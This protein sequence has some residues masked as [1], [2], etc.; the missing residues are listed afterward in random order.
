MKQLEQQTI[1]GA[2][3]SKVENAECD[4]AVGLG[5]LL[6]NNLNFCF[7]KSPRYASTEIE[8]SKLN[9]DRAFFICKCHTIRI[10]VT[11]L[12]NHT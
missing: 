4:Y 2:L 7:L 12:R 9:F 11:Y 6:G 8:S 10:S 1:N 5:N 3:T